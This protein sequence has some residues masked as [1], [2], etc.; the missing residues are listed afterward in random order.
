MGAINVAMAM[1]IQPNDPLFS[2][3]RL[4]KLP[5]P[6][7]C[8]GISRGHDVPIIGAAVMRTQLVELGKEKGPELVV[9]GK[10]FAKG[11][12]DWLGLIRGA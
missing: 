1:G 7:C 9:R 8:T 11:T 2:V 12:S 3:V 10:I 6:E 4:E 5:I